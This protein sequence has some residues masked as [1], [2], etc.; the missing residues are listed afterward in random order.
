MEY[1]IS[2]YKSHKTTDV[3]VGTE[4]IALSTLRPSGIA[5]FNGKRFDV[6]ADGEW[7]ESGEAVKIT[8]TSGGYVSVVKV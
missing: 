2:C 4:G 1:V 3:P 8:K 5:E 6:V 7:I